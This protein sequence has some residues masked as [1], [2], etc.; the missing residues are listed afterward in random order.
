MLMGSRRASAL[1]HDL[2][3]IDENSGRMHVIMLLPHVPVQIPALT[4]FRQTV[5]ENQRVEPDGKRQT[6]G[7]GAT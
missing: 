1:L 6:E 3:V 5:D 7:S 2:A 4:L